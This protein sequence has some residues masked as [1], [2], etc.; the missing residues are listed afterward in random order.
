MTCIS[1][2]SREGDAHGDEEEVGHGQVKDQQ[3]RRVPHLRVRAHL[4]RLY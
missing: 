1:T 2:Y 4:E 3:V